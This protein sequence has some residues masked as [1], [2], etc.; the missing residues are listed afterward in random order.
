M[1]QDPL[2]LSTATDY[3]T[4]IG[5]VRCC[6]EQYLFCT[7]NV[8]IGHMSSAT[9]NVLSLLNVSA[10]PNKISRYEQTITMRNRHSIFDVIK[11]SFPS[12][13]PTIQFRII[14]DRLKRDPR[15]EHFGS[16][17]HRSTRRPVITNSLSREIFADHLIQFYPDHFEWLLFHPEWL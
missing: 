1:I 10:F 11:T 14:D 5:N 4:F 6:H 13:N 7:E 12:R 2:Y 8:N 15:F 17:Y 3:K 16:Y 9:M